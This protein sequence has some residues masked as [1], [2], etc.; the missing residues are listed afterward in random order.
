MKYCSHCGAPVQ[1]RVPPGDDRKRFVC[2]ACHTIHYE[3]PKIVV[4]CIPV[5]E[6]KILLCRRAIEPRQGLWTLPAGYL[7]NGESVSEGA[8]RETFEEVRAVVSNLIPFAVFSLPF[9]SQV[10]LML[11]AQLDDLN[12]G[13]GTESLE[14]RLFGETEIP[15]DMLAFPVIRETLRKY[16][17][18]R[19]N[20]RFLFHIGDI[21]KD[22]TKQDGS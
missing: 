11:R 20:G 22:I 10:Y 6:N 2:E 9:I 16:Y 18:D 7:E 21:L 3:N 14:V 19:S 4:G 13:P 8:K 17:E 1:L 12:F 15:W 5:L